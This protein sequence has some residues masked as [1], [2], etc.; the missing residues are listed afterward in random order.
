MQKQGN[1][2][3]R[4][5]NKAY[6]QCLFNAV[7]VKIDYEP[8]L[9]LVWLLLHDTATELGEFR[10]WV[11]EHGKLVLRVVIGCGLKVPIEDLAV[12]ALGWADVN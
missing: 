1:K 8:T 12:E 5:Q 3:Q 10:V 9:D 6:R 2:E 7:D 4:K 11:G